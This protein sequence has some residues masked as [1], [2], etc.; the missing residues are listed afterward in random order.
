MPLTGD[1]SQP[2]RIGEVP[3]ARVILARTNARVIDEA[4]KALDDGLRPAIVGGVSALLAF[5]QG[6][7]RLMAGTPVDH[8]QELFGFA[9]WSAV[10]A[11]SGREDGAD[12][13]TLVTIIERHGTAALKSALS[14]LPTDEDAAD[15]VLSTGHKATLAVEGFFNETALVY[16]VG[17]TANSIRLSLRDNGIYLAAPRYSFA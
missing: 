8:P 17:H 16:G 9:D 3:E 1:P 14:S 4:L 13:R 5:I 6:A 7:E 2:G 15:I 12:L 10:K 11:A